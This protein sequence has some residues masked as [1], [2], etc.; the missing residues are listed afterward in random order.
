MTTHAKGHVILRTFSGGGTGPIE[1]RTLDL[2]LTATAAGNSYVF[3]DVGADL[4]RVEPDGTAVLMI[5][6]Q[7]PFTFTGVLKIDLDTGEV[8]LE[9][10]HSLEERLAEA[11][12]V[13]S[14]TSIPSRGG[15]LRGILLGGAAW[16]E[17]QLGRMGLA[18]RVLAWRRRQRE[19]RAGRKV[20]EARVFIRR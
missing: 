17:C 5:I 16:R 19:Q 6:G 4:V 2:R 15:C 20:G 8:I 10:R 1:L 3:R 18:S 13:L 7:L 14:V 12:A 9:P 11:C